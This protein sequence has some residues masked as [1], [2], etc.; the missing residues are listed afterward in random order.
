MSRSITL[1]APKGK[2]KELNKVWSN[3]ADEVV[4]IQL[5]GQRG[6]TASKLYQLITRAAQVNRGKTAEMMSEII[7]LAMA[8]STQI[9]D[10]KLFAELGLNRFE[11]LVDG[12]SFDVGRTVIKRH[13][14]AHVITDVVVLCQDLTQYWTITLRMPDGKMKSVT[15]TGG[16]LSD[17]WQELV[18][19]A[20]DGSQDDAKGCTV[21]VYQPVVETLAKES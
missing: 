12:I 19:V 5:A 13:D 14:G 21:S 7:K 9:E 11:D 4:P 2:E 1:Y 20:N 15:T 10:Y 17:Y 18:K 3:L 6:E 8:N 16:N